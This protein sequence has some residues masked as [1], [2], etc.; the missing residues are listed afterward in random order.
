MEMPN[1]DL[2][3]QAIN[4]VHQRQSEGLLFKLIREGFESF[5]KDGRISRLQD[6]YRETPDRQGVRE[7]VTIMIFREAYWPDL[8][9]RG[10]RF[11]LSSSS[12]EN[13]L[14]WF[15]AQVSAIFDEWLLS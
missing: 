10:F 6:V 4:E 14:P 1:I 11:V 5:K 13:P 8:T 3:S 9:P 7:A 15:D 12:E 2:L